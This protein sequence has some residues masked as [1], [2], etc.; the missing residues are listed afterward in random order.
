MSINVLQINVIGTHFT[1]NRII[2]ISLTKWNDIH[3]REENY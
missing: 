3:M 1:D 2:Q